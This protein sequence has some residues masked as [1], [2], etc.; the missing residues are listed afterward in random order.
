LKTNQPNNQPTKQTKELTHDE[1]AEEMT[2]G[3]RA[4]AALAEGLSSIPSTNMM[5][6]NHL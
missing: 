4:L 5:T 1:G 6:H 2:E 3:L